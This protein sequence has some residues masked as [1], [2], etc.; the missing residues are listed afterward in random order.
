MKIP[1]SGGLKKTVDSDVVGVRYLKKFEKRIKIA[2]QV[3]AKEPTIGGA[4]EGTI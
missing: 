2:F 3:K 4:G 1:M